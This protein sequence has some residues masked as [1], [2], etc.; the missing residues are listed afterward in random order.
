MVKNLPA[1][2]G[3]IPGSVRSPAEG[4]GNL[5]Q[6][7]CLEKSHEQRSLV[8]YNPWDQERVGHDLATKK[9]SIIHLI[10]HLPTYLPI[11]LCSLYPLCSHFSNLTFVLNETLSINKA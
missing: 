7:S 5:L 3:P 6:Y 11:Y 1:N 4:N 8:G 9:L 2:A 10:Y